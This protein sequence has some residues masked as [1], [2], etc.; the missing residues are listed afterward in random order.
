MPDGETTMY[1]EAEIL[2]KKVKSL[3]N[4]KKSSENIDEN[5]MM[6]NV[7]SSYYNRIEQ[8]ITALNV[9]SIRE[10]NHQE[11]RLAGQMSW[12]QLFKASLA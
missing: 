5:V 8:P 10:K 7:K 9:L 1:Y 3:L 4:S 6:V 11:R 2:E 12:A